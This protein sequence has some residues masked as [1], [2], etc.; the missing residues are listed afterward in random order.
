MLLS[1][2]GFGEAS[3]TVDEWSIKVEVRAV[4]NRHFKFTAR[5]GEPFSAFEGELEKLVRKRVHRG[6]VQ[7][8]V[9]VDRPARQ[10]DYRLNRLALESYSEQFKEYLGASPQLHAGAL[11]SLPGVVEERSRVEVDLEARWPELK[12]VV[13]AALERFDAVRRGEGRAMADELL[14][15]GRGIGDHTANIIA[16]NPEVVDAYRERLTERV[17]GLVKDLGVTIEPKDLIR[18]V[19][20]FAERSDNAE[21]LTRLAAH[22]E[23]F[24]QVVS[25]ES[26]AGRKLEFLVQEMGREAN[27]LGSKANDVAISR[28]VFEIKGRLEKIRELI[29][30]VE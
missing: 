4:N 16:R 7:M 5:V 26:S 23:Q 11:L 20:I 2:T 27:T 28:E 22:L 12:G 29:Q 10:E 15:L 1:M 24:E 30:N 17:R 25:R 8:S 18:E 3:G 6:T 13:E 9:R 21:E 14:A 19:A